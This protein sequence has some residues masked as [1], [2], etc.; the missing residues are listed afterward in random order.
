MEAAK[1]LG[2]PRVTVC[3]RQHHET[4]DVSVASA[5]PGAE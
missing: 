3:G 5:S 4:L 1:P 2:L